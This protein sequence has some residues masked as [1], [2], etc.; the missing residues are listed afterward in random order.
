MPPQRVEE[1]N[2]HLI[3]ALL[4]HPDISTFWNMRRELTEQE[5]SNLD[6]ELLLTKLILSNKSKSNEAFAYRKWILSKIIK[7]SCKDNVNSTMLILDKEFCLSEMAA[8]KS[9]NNYHAWT[10]RIWCFENVLRN[11]NL[12][13]YLNLISD[14]LEY[15]IKWIN[16]HVSE[17]T[18]FHYRQYLCKSI[19]KN[20]QRSSMYDVTYH[21]YIEPFVDIKFWNCNDTSN[22]NMLLGRREFVV[23]N[24]NQDS[25]RCYNYVYFITVLLSDLFL[26]IEKLNNVFPNHESIWYH[27][28]FVLFNLLHTAYEYHNI[29]WKRNTAV[30]E[31]SL[32]I[33]IDLNITSSNLDDVEENLT[34]QENGEKSPKL[35]KYEL[36]KVQNSYLYK[37]LV[38]TEQKF[39]K[40]N[41]SES[42]SDV[43]KEL[44][45]KHQKW[46]KYILCFNIS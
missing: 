30:K 10:H 42:C 9:Q 40:N 18:G 41:S 45:K 46:L 16:T 7:N 39:I 25:L 21:C 29:T 37:L 20:T 38:E 15:S 22:L 11:T 1:V 43:Q 3:G 31:S 27:R 6:K 28:R 13:E 26:F 24:R 36:D 33:S 4:I 8:E 44:A 32:I 19:L 34:L 35:L 23:A 14:Q 12:P 2:K 5:N 17:H